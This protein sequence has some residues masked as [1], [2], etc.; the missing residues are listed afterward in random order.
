MHGYYHQSCMTTFTTIATKHIHSSN[1]ENVIQ[2][3]IHIAISD[4]IFSIKVGHVNCN[5]IIAINYMSIKV[6]S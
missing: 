6:V 5:H 1:L 4:Y 3:T 2:V